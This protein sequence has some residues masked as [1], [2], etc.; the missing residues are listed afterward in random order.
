MNALGHAKKH[1]N[2]E[3]NN[4]LVDLAKKA[5]VELKKLQR[6]KRKEEANQKKT[7]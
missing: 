7:L 1:F 6:D 2:K 3:N 4:K 5:Q